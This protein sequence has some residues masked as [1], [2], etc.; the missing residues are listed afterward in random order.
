MNRSLSRAVAALALAVFVVATGPAASEPFNIR[1]GWSTAPS[2]VTPLLPLIPKDVYKHWGKSYVVEP[3]FM[4]GTS[5]MLPALASGDVELVG[6][7][8]QTHANLAITGQMDVRAIAG[9]LGSKPP[10][11]DEGFWVRTEDN[12]NK[13][14]DLKGKIAAINSRGSGVDA[15]LR[16]ML[17]DHGLQDQSDYTIVEVPFPQMFTALMTKKVHTTFLV[18]P[19]SRIAEKNP[20][21]KKLFTFRDALGPTETVVWSAK[22]E[23]VAAH[24]AAFVDFLED[25]I[26]ARKWLYDPKN[27]DAAVQ[28]VAKVTKRP[29]KQFAEWVFTKEDTYRP[30]DCM[31]DVALLQKNVAI[32]QKMGFVKGNVDIAKFVDLSLVKEA[33]ARLGM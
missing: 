18:L 22:T 6:Y 27:H 30:V 20:G 16:K 1:I 32:L 4:R 5:V 13:V 3:I 23:T 11:S 24:R 14:E 2:H 29:A 25:N 7:A 17:L 19:F 8:Y 31:I 33:K 26:R 15:T 28:I 10:Y 9:V 21:L 12:I